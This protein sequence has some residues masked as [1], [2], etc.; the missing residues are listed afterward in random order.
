MTKKRTPASLPCEIEGWTGSLIQSGGDTTRGEGFT[1]SI[2]WKEWEISGLIALQDEQMVITQILI[3]PNSDSI[4]HGG[5]VSSTLKFPLGRIRADIEKM[6]VNNIETWVGQDQQHVEELRDENRLL[7]ALLNAAESERP[8]AVHRGRK[9]YSEDELRAIARIYL[10][11]QYQY[12]VDRIAE[13]MA[14]VL[15][16]T[17]STTNRKIRR[18]T[19]AGF[20]GPAQQGRG[21]RMP[22]SRLNKADL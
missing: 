11:F 2:P 15:E 20:L 1:F 10:S 18:A 7:E 9:P 5:V 13:R 16:L 8:V 22:G 19:Q 6:I 17:L 3:Q 21:G 12:G 4:P 14:E